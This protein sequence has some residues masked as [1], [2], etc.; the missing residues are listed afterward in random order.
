MRGVVTAG[1]LSGLESLDLL[2]CFDAVYG[3]SAGALAGAYFVAGQM[4]FGTTT[5]YEDVNNR[6][7]IDLF[8]LIRGQP[9]MDLD[10]IFENVM[11]DRKP[12]D[13]IMI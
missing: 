11:T 6:W 4:R 10:F 9:V 8:R 2:S 12:L 5:F 3:T 7:F 13:C 1:M